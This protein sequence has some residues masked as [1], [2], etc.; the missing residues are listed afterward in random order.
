MGRED[1]GAAVDGL[2]SFEPVVAVDQLDAILLQLVGDMGVVDEV[3]E[4]SD[5]LPRVGFRRLLRGADRLDDAVAIAT[6]GDLEDVHGLESNRGSKRRSVRRRY[7]GV[8]PQTLAWH[9]APLAWAGGPASGVSGLAADAR[10]WVGRAAAGYREPARLAPAAGAEARAVRRAYPMLIGPPW[11]LRIFKKARMLSAA[12]T[13][14]KPPTT[15]DAIR[16]RVNT[17][18]PRS[19]RMM[20]TRMFAKFTMTFMLR[21]LNAELHASASAR[22]RSEIRSATS[23]MPTESRTRP[24]A[25]A[26]A[27]RVS[28]GMDEWVIAAG[29]AINH[30]TPARLSA[31]VNPPAPSADAR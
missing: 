13:M 25:T 17:E 19:S 27:R 1:D 24:S 7:E 10:A 31:T 16:C 12:R 30:A 9:E 3:A 26:W 15:Y 23:S 28:T 2:E 22:S 8:T 20:A 14:M 6:R 4:H 11:T 21:L 29:S 18:S 5:L